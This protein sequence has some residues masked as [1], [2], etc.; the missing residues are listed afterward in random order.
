VLLSS[1][2]LSLL[3]SAQQPRDDDLGTR[4]L[5]ILELA[6][7]PSELAIDDLRRRIAFLGPEAV[8]PVLEL[9]A[10]GQG[11]DSDAEPLV[12]GLTAR[13]RDVLLGSLAMSATE[14]VIGLLE[15]R[16]AE[17]PCPKLVMEVL[18]ELGRAADIRLGLA[19]VEPTSNNAF[20]EA[21][22]RIL[23]R[24]LG[25]YA[26]LRTH[27]LEAPPDAASTLVRAASATGSHE[28]LQLMLELLGQDPGLDRVLLTHIGQIGQVAPW[29][30][31]DSAR[32]RVRGYLAGTDESM[33]RAALYATGGL[34]DFEAVE[35][36]IELLGSD[37]RSLSE[38]AHW[39]LKTTTGLGFSP[40]Q[41]RWQAWFASESEWYERNQ[42]RL[43]GRIAHSS[44]RG[45]A[46]ALRELSTCR[47]QRVRIAEGMLGLLNHADPFVR[48]E[49]CLALRN[50]GAEV[51]V[52]A[53]MTSMT[54]ADQGVAQEAWRALQ[55]ITG[56]QVPF[57]I[58]AWSRELETEL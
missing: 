20:E 38:A 43:F 54:D 9:L 22:T 40:D 24:D 44:S 46:D 16:T 39:A 26:V 13:R 7:G 47:Y 30:A 29:Y 5:A 34:R 3:A 35:V 19:V 12:G 52:P 23:R 2:C 11:C 36:A 28:A 25:T 37:S 21:V 8:M 27:I 50:L 56:K 51:A 53:L 45:I 15:Q 31:D 10:S 57:G 32:R 17:R 42:G 55:S 1:L 14:T 49:T 33:Q 18:A 41:Q 6:D 58:E 48:R 4:I